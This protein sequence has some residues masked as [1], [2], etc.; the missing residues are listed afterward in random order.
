MEMHSLKPTPPPSAALS[1]L[2]Q[3]TWGH[4]N[5]RRKY[6]CGL[7]VGLM[8]VSAFAEVISLGAVLPFLGILT[9]PDR[10]Y[11]HPVVAGFASKIG[12]TTADQLLLPITV[13][14]VVAALLAGAVRLLQ[15][16]ANMRFSYATGHDL[17]T[18]AYLRSLYQPYKTHLGR[19]SS[20]VI[21]GVDKVDQLLSL[22]LQ[23]LTLLSALVLVIFIVLTL[24]VIDPLVAILAFLGFGIFYGLV[25]WLT[26]RR[27]QKNSQMIARLQPLRLKAA[28]EG[29]GAIRDVIIGGHQKTY[30]DIVRRADLPVRIALGNNTFIGD[31]PRYVVETFGIVLIAFISYGLA[32]QKGE[33]TAVLPIL[34]ALAFGAQRLLPALQQI[35]RAWSSMAG[36]RASIED[37]L[38]LLDQPMPEEALSPPPPP[39]DFRR[40]IRFESVKFQYS[41]EGPLVLAGLDLT[42]PYGARV[43][44]VGCT[45][46]GKSTTLDLLMGLLLPTSGEILVDGL[47]LQGERLRAWQRIIAHVSQSIFLADTTLAE[48]IAFGIPPEAIDMDRVRQAAQ[49]AHIAE[50]IESSPAGYNTMVGERGIRLSGGQRQRIGIAR[51]LY[52]QANVLVLDEGTSALDNIT[53][54]AVM[55]DIDKL[56]R[57]LTILIIAHRLTTLS[58]C[59]M[60]VQLERDKMATQR[61]YEQLLDQSPTFRSMAE[62]SGLE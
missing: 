52:K 31:S 26:R 57:D 24:L 36:S 43:G 42:I 44:F 60:I 33:F 40:D 41:H 6:Q 35:Y 54:R 38:D 11:K 53:E 37:A 5:R 49:R 48:N 46:S 15:L 29:L 58:R 18:A 39:L 20:E 62:I 47:P 21:N 16:W 25:M 13:I 55:D 28:L 22:L 50:F 23:T 2:L 30:S 51:A 14:F 7:L 12:V 32:R 10:V 17:G 19:N 34:G 8:F 4:L 1:K 3:R 9:A 59:D 61:T 45:G 27:L 56:G